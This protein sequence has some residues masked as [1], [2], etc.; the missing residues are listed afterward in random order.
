MFTGRKKIVKDS[1]KPITELEEQVGQA[2]LE[3]ETNS[4]DLKADLKDLVIS[5]AKEVEVSSTKKAVVIFVPYRQL[6]AYH[7]IQH[8]GLVR[9][10][11]KK[12]SGK[13][14]IIL[15]QRRILP[16]PSKNNHKK[17]QK[18]PF[19]RT[20]TAVHAAILEDLVYPTEIV[21][22]RLRVRTDG[23]KLQKVY[24]DPKDQTNQENKLETFSAVYKKITG[25][26]TTFEFPQ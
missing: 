23:S 13:H 6:K 10:L 4:N 21:G 19:S 15:G 14:V 7:R 3:L 1:T 17:Q 26:I 22:K 20:T 2:L 12:F 16:K 5:S 11:E 8:R 18:R 25:K 9:E 24:L